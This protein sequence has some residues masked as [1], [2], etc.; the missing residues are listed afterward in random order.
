MLNKVNVGTTPNDGTGD[1][2][3]AAMGLVNSAIEAINYRTVVSVKE[4]GAVG[5]GVTDDTAAVNA[6]SAEIAAA[7]GGAVFFPK[8]NYRLA[9]AP[10]EIATGVSWVPEGHLITTLTQDATLSA[11]DGFIRLGG[12]DHFI[13]DF[14]IEA[15]AGR[16]NG[17]AIQMIAT[18]SSGKGSFSRIGDVYITGAGTWERGISANGLAKNTG[19]LGI[20]TLAI[21]AGTQIFQCT[22]ASLYL[23]GVK[24]CTAY[25][26]SGLIP[27]PSSP[28]LGALVITGDATVTSD[29]VVIIAAALDDISIDRCINVQV[30]A[31][32]CGD[33]TIGGNAQNSSIRC[34]TAAAVTNGGSACIVERNLDR[35]GAP[36]LG[37]HHI[38]A[39]GGSSYGLT[40]AGATGA[41]TL[42]SN[43]A[44]HTIQTANGTQG[45]EVLAVL[46]AAA[47]TSLLVQQVT[48]A[49]ANAANAAIK[50]GTNSATGRSI[51]AG[52]T[53][54]ASGADYAE[55]ETKRPDCGTIAAGDIVGIDSD[56]HLTDQW[57]HAIAFAVKSTNPAYVGGDAWAAA[58]GAAPEK[59]R[60]QV[61]KD[62]AGRVIAEESTE[63][64]VG[65]V[66]SWA[67]ARAAFDARLEAARQ[68]VDR[69][70][71][72]GKTPVN[73]TGAIPGQWIVPVRRGTGITGAAK[74]WS[75]MTDDERQITVG[76][77]RR[78][79]ADGR[80]EVTVR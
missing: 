3:R 9:S 32:S 7:G 27:T 67:A 26:G 71:Y 22:E 35:L 39:A 29:N 44:R 30:V 80:A 12:V 36:T 63:A 66:G 74:P 2:L 43:D 57:Q 8:G 6:A 56:G 37:D 18:S 20:R 77:V 72:A 48:N 34:N 16:T 49:G 45:D 55:Y 24:N 59:P 68:Q 61:T 58:L 73:V 13:G 31:P 23:S 51:N 4:H 1:S 47:N 69:I 40:V 54:N 52:G 76:R 25:L 60:R 28:S 11:G 65:R 15:A 17:H 46:D 41:H 79:L 53:V 14:I 64:Y 21:G 70:A 10:A 75:A 33:I 19:A 62:R 78:V 50:V 42:A 5:D 38:Y